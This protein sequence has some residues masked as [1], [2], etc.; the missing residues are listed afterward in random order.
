MSRQASLAA[1][2]FAAGEVESSLQAA[3]A[4]VD[5]ARWV[6]EQDEL[7]GQPDLTILVNDAAQAVRRALEEAQAV[8]KREREAGRV[9]RQASLILGNPLR[10]GADG[11]GMALRP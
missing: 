2:L 5:E 3:S 10:D 6:M 9:E 8:N 11:G 1:R 7:G 4:Q